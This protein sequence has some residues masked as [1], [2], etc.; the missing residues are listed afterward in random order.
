[1]L[2]E[3]RINEMRESAIMAEEKKILNYLRGAGI[4]PICVEWNPW[5][6]KSCIIEV[7]EE[8]IFD[9]D[10]LMQVIGYY[11]LEE[12]RYHYEDGTNT[13]GHIYIAL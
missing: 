4:K 9:C 12:E 6:I 8:R 11:S 7:P 13:I 2:L 5:P 1:M 3:D 10:T